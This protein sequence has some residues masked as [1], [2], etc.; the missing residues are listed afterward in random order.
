MNISFIIS[1]FGEISLN[2]MLLLQTQTSFPEGSQHNV[3]VFAAIKLFTRPFRS[4][5]MSVQS[6]ETTT[7]GEALCDEAMQLRV[8]SIGIWPTNFNDSIPLGGISTCGNGPEF[9]QQQRCRC[10]QLLDEKQT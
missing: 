8:D 10:L 7:A 9:N 1:N 2:N 6:S 5:R 3:N 4:I